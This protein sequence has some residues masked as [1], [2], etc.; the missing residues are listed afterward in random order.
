MYM[1]RRL[2]RPRLTFFFR[3]LVYI[4]LGPKSFYGTTEHSALLAQMMDFVLL[5]IY[6][7]F[8]AD[9]IPEISIIYRAHAA[10]W[11]AA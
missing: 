11:G 5:I 8:R 10:A 7:S 3:S 4:H 1:Y 2:A 6:A 9:K